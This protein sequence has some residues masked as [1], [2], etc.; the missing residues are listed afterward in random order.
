MSI[1][2]FGSSYTDVGNTNSDFLIKTR[3]KIKIQW[4]N[5]F[6]DLI[7]DGK[8]NSDAKFI[9]QENE[10]G[11]KDGIY[12]LSDD[13]VILK[14][15]DKE[16]SL[17]GEV[18]NTYVS[19]QGEQQTTS[20]Q[21]FIALNNIG[22]LYNS[23]SDLGTDYVQNGIV[24]ITSEQKLY[25]IK[26]GEVSPF[27]VEIPN[28]YT[29]QF[30]IQKSDTNKGSLLILGEGIENS[31][32]F[33][34]FY[35]YN[36]SGG[37]YLDS[38]G[39]IYF[40]V[41]DSERVI[42]DTDQTLFKNEVVSS[43]FKS[44]YATKNTGF[45]LYVEGSQS[46]LEVDNLIVRNSSEN[47]N[48]SN[49]LYP[50]YWDYKSNIVKSAE[51]S[52]VEGTQEN[53][54]FE[55]TLLYQNEF[56]VGDVLFTYIPYKEEYES[57]EPSETE[58]EEIYDT[59]K[60]VLVPLKVI[61][62]DSETIQVSII[63]ELFN[64]SVAIYDIID[65]IKG[66]QL[67]YINTEGETS[68]ILRR[69]ENNIDLIEVSEPN[70]ALE[71]NVLFRIGN[72]KELGLKAIN[73]RQEVPFDKNGIYS[74][75]AIFTEAQY[76][77]NYN[78]PLTDDS[79]KFASTEWVKDNI[80]IYKP[81]NGINIDYDII[82]AKVYPSDKYLENSSEGIKTKDIDNAIQTA[83]NEANQY[84]DNSIKTTK[85][86]LINYTDT[87][88]KNATDTLNQN[89][90]NTSNNLTQY[91]D[92]QI[93]DT[94]NYI[95]NQDN[96]IL[97]QSKQYTDSVKDNIINQFT[98]IQPDLYYNYKTA[99]STDI[100]NW[101]KN[102]NTLKGII[103]SATSDKYS[104]VSHNGIITTQLVNNKVHITAYVAS[105]TEDNTTTYRSIDCIVDSD[106]FNIDSLS[107]YILF[108]RYAGYYYSKSA[109]GDETTPVQFYYLGISQGS[110]IVN[111]QWPYL[112]QWD[113]IKWTLIDK[114]VEDTTSYLFIR[115]TDKC[116]Y[117]DSTTLQ[118]NSFPGGFIDYIKDNSE[119]QVGFGVSK[120]IPNNNIRD[121]VICNERLQ[122]LN[123]LITSPTYNI[124]PTNKSYGYLWAI[125]SKYA[126]TQF[127]KW[128]LLASKTTSTTVNTDSVWTFGNCSTPSN[129][130]YDVYR[131]DDN[132]IILD[133]NLGNFEFKS[134]IG[135]YENWQDKVWVKSF[136]RYTLC[137]ILNNNKLLYNDI[138]GWDFHWQTIFVGKS[139]GWL[140]IYFGEPTPPK[141]D[142]P[143]DPEYFPRTTIYELNG[144]I[145]SYGYSVEFRFEG[146][147]L[148][149][150]YNNIGM[151]Q[152]ASVGTRCS[153][154]K[155]FYDV[156]FTGYSVIVNDLTTGSRRFIKV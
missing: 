70:N 47:E 102:N 77:N 128:Q 121:E 1:Q 53:D 14:V 30:V 49:Y 57:S 138:T 115:S 94:K 52:Y 87:S 123:S 17:L 136:I 108:S 149:K 13:S 79:S 105:I 80:I 133:Q 68:T 3:G 127:D 12:V 104:I 125:E 66:Q 118:Q 98:I 56:K 44:E 31:L 112:W 2:L 38:N 151:G 119:H 64:S 8:I 155:W 120:Y 82:S 54:N 86:Q 55:L 122:F 58:E 35:L 116:I 96:S 124:K 20:E 37:T 67:F 78:L 113:N 129:Q 5:K 7:K 92:T 22:F 75:S 89:I 117:T 110:F 150:L 15:G 45:R 103:Q 73:E 99:T 43:M 21:K 51:E 106:N 147:T 26:D 148:G 137:T 60:N 61:T 36:E 27:N 146:V 143:N 154:S 114:Y 72:T 50:I 18:G 46:T 42:I 130:G 145:I 90:T 29:K 65:S 126:I 11:A 107:T 10:I 9:Y 28:P 19:F 85:E 93:S 97:D 4:G 141:S 69:K 144:Q 84:T 76:T 63:S 152:W 25:I 16:L 91:I 131:V 62:S 48:S 101:I 153:F 109:N 33:N 81:G 140:G 71:N 95:D 23:L 40:K 34:S 132:G 39:R 24:Y 111:S 83:K 74:D 41:N 59:Y 142:D 139:G 32:A 88:V 156:D 135:T 6:I 134:G 100:S